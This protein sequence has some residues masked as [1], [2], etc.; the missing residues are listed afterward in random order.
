[1]TIAK[2]SASADV[3]A[4]GRNSRALPVTRYVA[5]LLPPPEVLFKKEAWATN[6][7]LHLPPRTFPASVGSSLAQ[8]GGINIASIRSSSLA[9]MIRAARR[10]VVWRPAQEKLERTADERG[11]SP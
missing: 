5:Q 7:L 9:G 8:F 4:L 11:I 2:A 10:T 1:M 3:S 6:V